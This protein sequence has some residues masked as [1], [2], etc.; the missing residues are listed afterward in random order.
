MYASGGIAYR[1]DGAARRTLEQPGPGPAKSSHKQ[2][3]IPRA[4]TSSEERSRSEEKPAANRLLASLKR[5]KLLQ[6]K[7]G[8]GRFVMHYSGNQLIE[9]TKGRY[10]PGFP[11]P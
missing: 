2:P 3:D 11:S 4:A 8:I 9:A 6:Q 1:N 7:N 10:P 5:E